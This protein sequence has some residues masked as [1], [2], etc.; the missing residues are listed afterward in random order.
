MNMGTLDSSTPLRCAQNLQGHIREMKMEW[1]RERAT[2]RV[3]P[4]TGLPGPIFIGMIGAGACAGITMALSGH[5][6]G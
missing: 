5:I 4:T 3:A 6:R 2:T 1:L